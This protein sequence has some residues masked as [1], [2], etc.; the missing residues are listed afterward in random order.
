MEN[1]TGKHTKGQRIL[2]M[3][4]VI[5]LVL[6]YIVTLISALLSTPVAPTLFKVCIFSSLLI[7][8]LIWGNMLIAKL[9]SRH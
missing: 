7:P 5:L 1:N 6:L 9:L 8:L 3:T 4:G 2:A